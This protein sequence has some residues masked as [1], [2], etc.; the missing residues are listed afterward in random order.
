MID[1]LKSEELLQKA[2]G[3]F[4][5]ATL[6]QKR[7]A[8]LMEGARPLVDRGDLT[9]LELVVEEIRQGK[10][11]IVDDEV[12]AVAEAAVDAAAGSGY[13]GVV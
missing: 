3:K 12:V 2:G 4:R 13:A 6:M 5:L 1:A 8:Q 7:L 11:E 10:V 9:P